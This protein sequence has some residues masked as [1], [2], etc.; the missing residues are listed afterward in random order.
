MIGDFIQPGERGLIG[1]QSR[2]PFFL[3]YGVVVLRPSQR[4]KSGSVK[5]CT[6]RVASITKRRDYTTF[7]LWHS[8]ELNETPL[9]PRNHG[10]R[11]INDFKLAENVFDMDFHGVF[12]D[13]QFRPDF[14][15]AQAFGD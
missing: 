15:V 2:F 7:W 10:L 3:F 1:L 4:I 14:L 12:R 11:P 13:V 5:P 8:I 9:R 6:T